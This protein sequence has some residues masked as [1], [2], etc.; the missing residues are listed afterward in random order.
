[1]FRCQNGTGVAQALSSHFA[2]PVMFGQVKNSSRIPVIFTIEPPKASSGVLRV[3]PLAG[4]LLGNQ[5]ATLQ[6][7]FAPRETKCYRFNLPV[8][9]PRCRYASFQR[10]STIN[11][12]TAGRSTK[13]MVEPDAKTLP[14]EDPPLLKQKMRS[15][16]SRL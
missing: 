2:P 10:Q 16:L 15:S 13:Y 9:V 8:K 5:T 11:A 4:F 14:R 6:M 1:M 7:L 3:F 12:H